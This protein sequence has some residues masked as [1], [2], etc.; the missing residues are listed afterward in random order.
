MIGGPTTTPTGPTSRLD[1]SLRQRSLVG[2]GC[3]TRFESHKGWTDEGGP[4]SDTEPSAGGRRENQGLVHRPAPA[5]GGSDVRPRGRP[6]PSRQPWCLRVG[7]AGVR[8]TGGRL[9]PPD[10]A[11]RALARSA[12]GATRDGRVPAAAHQL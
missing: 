9:P 12:G 10:V 7:C 4:V 5:A 3:R 1:T 2:G 6:T 11:V 8:G